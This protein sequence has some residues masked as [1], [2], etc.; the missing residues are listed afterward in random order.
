MIPNTRRKPSCS[1]CLE[2]GH[3]AR[4]YKCRIVSEYKAN[5]IKAGEVMEMAARLGNPAYYEVKQPDDETRE[6]IVEWISRGGSNA[7][8]SDAWHLVLLNIYFSTMENVT[9]M[10]NWIEVTVLGK[11]GVLLEGWE[12]AYF[13]AHEI[14]TWLEKN[15]ASR[16]R[17]KHCLS[18]LRKQTAIH[19]LSQESMH[20]HYSELS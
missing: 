11:R 13:P 14:G 6:R 3:R 19:H 17:K 8:P 9:V 18:A 7:V 1:L 5:L 2:E 20:G 10:Y 16:Q 12:T 15:C 4:G